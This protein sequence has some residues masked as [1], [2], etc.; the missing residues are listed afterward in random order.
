MTRIFLNE[1]TDEQRQLPLPEPGKWKPEADFLE[2]YA[3]DIYIKGNV[4]DR[5]VNSVPSVFA[6]P[7]QF[8]QALAD[9]Q[10]PMHAT[11]VSQWRGLLA[12]FA[13]RKALDIPLQVSRFQLRDDAGDR[14]ADRQFV[15]ILQAQAPRPASEWKT[16][17]LLYCEGQLIGATSPWTIVYTPTEYRLASGIPWIDADGMLTDPSLSLQ[18]GSDN[19]ELRA[20]VTWL[21][22]VLSQHPWN[23]PQHHEKKAG[24]I[25]RELLTWRDEL[26]RVAQP[27]PGGK[28]IPSFAQATGTAAPFLSTLDIP[29]LR[30]TVSSSLQL[31]DD[32]GCGAIVLSRTA[33]RNPRWAKQRVFG[34]VR[35]EHLDLSAAALPQ[36]RGDAGWRTKTGV[37]VDHPYIVA[38]EYFFSPRILRIPLSGAAAS[39]GSTQYVLPLTPAFFNHFDAATL[40][41]GMLSMEET[42]EGV[43]VRLRLPLR[44]GSQL[45][46]EREYRQADVETVPEGQH[47]PA[48]AI[49]PDFFDQ[50]WHDYDA[51]LV[52]A[53]E[54]EEKRRGNRLQFA[55]LAGR[56]VVFPPAKMT[57]ETGQ[58][59]LWRWAD[60]AVPSRDDE[61]NLTP[62]LGFSVS[63]SQSGYAPVGLGVIIRR[64]VKPTEPA[65]RSWDIGVDFGTSNTQI[66]VR[67][68]EGD[69][70]PLTIQPRTLLLTHPTRLTSDRLRDL[71][72]ERAV[73][74]PFPTLLT[75]EPVLV[76]TRT[77][78][79]KK[80]VGM[81]PVGIDATRLGRASDDFVKDLKWTADETAQ[82]QYLDA[83]TRFIFA[84]A[85]AAGVKRLR[86]HWSYPLSLP[87]RIRT[88]MESFWSTLGEA[89]KAEGFEIAGVAAASES[90]A[91]SRYVFAN[92]ILPIGDDSLS[93]GIDVGGGSTDVAFWAGQTLIDRV[94]LNVAA[95]DVIRLAAR[96]ESL[97]RALLALSG[98]SESG[99]LA[100]ALAARPEIIWNAL[101]QI[102]GSPSA[103][104]AHPFIVA[105]NKTNSEDWRK[106]RTAA[107]LA[108]GGISFYLGIHAGGGAHGNMATSNV[109]IYVGGRGSSVFSWVATADSL[110]E[111]IA[112][113]FLKG[114]Q[115]SR[116]DARPDIEVAGPV[117]GNAKRALLKDEVAG[118]LIER[119]ELSAP[120]REGF[121]VNTTVAGEVH[122]TDSSGAEVQW[123]DALNTARI[124]TLKPPAN[125]N[126]SYIAF[127]LKQLARP[128][129]DEIALDTNGL[130]SLQLSQNWAI[131]DMRKKTDEY[132]LQP[133]FGYEL[134]ALIRKYAETAAAARG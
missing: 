84:E 74:P 17:L 133:I 28:T 9:D 13:L 37:R 95:N 47:I 65:E 118:G 12:A 45:E 42:N 88:T 101:L 57:D 120:T 51:I 61:K 58:I 68:S 117:V 40:Q 110:R 116:A 69:E 3:H 10:H 11:I 29:P 79:E 119:K 91:V 73:T 98:G 53:T 103:P 130:A 71:Y 26:R 67:E 104:Y 39:F 106:A 87:A 128:V 48:L 27:L 21:E 6:R 82:K 33:L 105:M 44:G 34:S 36:A 32:D 59:A 31:A 115:I 2:K 83:L 49:W 93:V 43:N 62:P 131:S 22:V 111:L 109:A 94:S 38:E 108:L 126:S 25:R 114:L 16:W 50:N 64:S 96:F 90:D 127:F 78:A 112:R 100:P 24:H 52:D 97:N 7:I 30:E 60:Y 15:R 134:K 1:L 80:T 81:I 72:S 19:E 113:Q 63:L 77:A 75:R 41:R 23:M 123:Q 92:D 122:W 107:Y 85:R 102:S 124:A 35:V 20:L 56:G 129:A 4:A 125:H 5:L 66:K 18:E 89:R 55:P 70:R 8:Y 86:L 99:I 14:D 54:N 46:V 121:D 132:V 76:V